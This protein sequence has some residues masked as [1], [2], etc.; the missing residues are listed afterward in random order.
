MCKKDIVTLTSI[1][2]RTK[3]LVCST[4]AYNNVPWI[5]LEV[6]PLKLLALNKIKKAN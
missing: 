1:L 6:N 4:E 5:R 3:V 2:S